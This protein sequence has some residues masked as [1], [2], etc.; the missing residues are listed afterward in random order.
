MN[1]TITIILCLL[2]YIVSL[3]TINFIESRIF[4]IKRMRTKYD[5]LLLTKNKRKLDEKSFN[6]GGF[7]ILLLI[8][9]PS[10]LVYPIIYAI[11][12]SIFLCMIVFTIIFILYNIY[13]YCKYDILEYINYYSYDSFDWDKIYGI[14]IDENIK[15]ECFSIHNINY[16]KYKREK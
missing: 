8:L 1:T 12:K 3:V 5:I 14:D 15:R 13:K 11:N 7:V 4:F 16:D 2:W 10:I 6:L 9:S